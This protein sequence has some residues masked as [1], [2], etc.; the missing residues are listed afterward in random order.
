MKTRRK[1][2]ICWRNDINRWKAAS[3]TH[4]K[5][6]TDTFYYWYDEEVPESGLSYKENIQRGRSTFPTQWEE[7]ILWQFLSKRGNIYYANWSISGCPEFN[8]P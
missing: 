8:T 7:N 3:W 6:N 5:P 2:A 1:E 4:T